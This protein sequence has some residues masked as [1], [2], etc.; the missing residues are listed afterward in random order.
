MAPWT[1]ASF[2]ERSNV[3]S[4]LLRQLVDATDELRGML[5]VL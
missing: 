1:E 3:T 5:A 2:T 4:R